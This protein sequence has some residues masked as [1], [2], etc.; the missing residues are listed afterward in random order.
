MFE[1]LIVIVQREYFAEDIYSDIGYRWC[2]WLAHSRVDALPQRLIC[3]IV[4]TKRKLI[5]DTPFQNS[6]DS[7]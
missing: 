2:S 6:L 7:I 1:I 4:F 5:V 3:S